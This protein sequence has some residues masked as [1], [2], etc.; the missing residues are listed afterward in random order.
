MT[1]VCFFIGVLAVTGIPPFS[2]FWS[3]L[4]LVV[5]IMELKGAAMPL[6]AVPYYLEIVLGVLLVPEGGA[7]AAVR[8]AVAGG[9]G[10]RA[11]RPCRAPRF[12]N[13]VLVA[14]AALTVLMPLIV[15][16]FVR[17]L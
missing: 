9:A 6:I 11:R 10:D 8:R 7:A 4:T 2:C 17:A 1:A 12:A 14:L 15:Y 5:G 16:P 13:A 3:K